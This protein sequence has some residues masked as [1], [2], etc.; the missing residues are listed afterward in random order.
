MYTEAIY[1][2]LSLMSISKNQ[3]YSVLFSHLVTRASA[4]VNFQCAYIHTLTTAIY[5]YTAY[6]SKL[7]LNSS[8]SMPLRPSPPFTQSL[9]S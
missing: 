3:Y 2:S 5:C 6:A 7:P 1:V 4:N 8:S 9:P